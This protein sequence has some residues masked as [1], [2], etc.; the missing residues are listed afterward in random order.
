MAQTP[1]GAVGLL[2]QEVVGARLCDGTRRWGRI[3]EEGHIKAY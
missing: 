2:L 1:S 3:L